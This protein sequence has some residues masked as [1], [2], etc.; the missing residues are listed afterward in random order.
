MKVLTIKLS[1]SLLLSLFA[2]YQLISGY[3][4]RYLSTFLTINRNL[5]QSSSDKSTQLNCIG[6]ELT[7]LSMDEVPF[8]S[9]TDNSWKTS[10]NPNIVAIRR[11][12]FSTRPELITFDAFSTLI[13]PSQS[14]GRW[15]REALNRACDMKVRLPRPALFTAAF[16]KA[17]A[18]R[19]V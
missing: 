5:P 18:A 4:N 17:Y 19:Y 1:L 12:P 16:K 14:I 11:E 3:S 2:P 7:P 10:V 8:P 6:T 9:D 15:Y 13:E